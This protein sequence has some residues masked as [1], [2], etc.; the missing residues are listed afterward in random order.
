MLRYSQIERHT[1]TPR[2]GRK[3]R[4]KMKEQDINIT[5]SIEYGEYLKALSYLA[6]GYVSRIR[7]QFAERA[8]DKYMDETT[9]RIVLEYGKEY[10]KLQESRLRDFRHCAHF[11][12]ATTG[13]LEDSV[14]N[15]AQSY[16]KTIKM[17]F[18][19]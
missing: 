14:L 3:E 2:R 15:N 7:V 16:G 4:K 10:E 11:G 1:T 18:D 9:R 19:I 8:Y 13:A 6:S 12:A 5:T 17:L